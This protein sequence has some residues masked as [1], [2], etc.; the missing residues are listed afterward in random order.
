MNRQTAFPNY[1]QEAFRT[2]L[3]AK[4]TLPERLSKTQP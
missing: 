2:I 4:D 1:P 3:I